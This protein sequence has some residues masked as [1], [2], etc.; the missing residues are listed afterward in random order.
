MCTDSN[1]FR[2]PQKASASACAPHT[3][4][5]LGFGLGSTWRVRERERCAGHGPTKARPSTPITASQSAAR[6]LAERVHG[7]GLNARLRSIW[8]RM[9]RSRMSGRLRSGRWHRGDRP[10]TEKTCVGK[11]SAGASLG[12]GRVERTDVGQRLASHRGSAIHLDTRR[13]DGQISER[14][15][16][17]S[18]AGLDS[19]T[20]SSIDNGNLALREGRWAFEIAEDSMLDL[21][22][23]R[24]EAS[25]ASSRS[26]L[27]TGFERRPCTG[28]RTR[29]SITRA[30]VR[31][32][33][34]STRAPMWN[35]QDSIT[36]TASECLHAA[37]VRAPICP[38]LEYDTGAGGRHARESAM[39]DLV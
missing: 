22:T 26:I 33:H 7:S 21:G 37:R 30:R 24:G 19:R 31:Q 1:I 16:T 32:D 20:V 36:Q 13:P 6:V 12:G 15:T 9:R 4:G 10:R 5:P 27:K 35:P 29:G 8:N 3:A 11:R 18:G 2:P 28:H 34:K 23:G 25:H 14:L 38:A 17:E 39:R